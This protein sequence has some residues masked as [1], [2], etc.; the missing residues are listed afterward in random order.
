MHKVS[1]TTLKQITKVLDKLSG[2]LHS[3]NTLINYKT[4]TK[5]KKKAKELSK[6]IKDN[7][8]QVE[9]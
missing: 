7:Y 5:D 8:T 4:F 2:T 9:I 1:H 3:G 6:L